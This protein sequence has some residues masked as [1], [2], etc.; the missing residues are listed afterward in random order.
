M[1]PLI[2]LPFP[3]HLHA[4]HSLLNLQLSLHF[5][6]FQVG[7][8][9]LRARLTLWGCEK[10]YGCVHLIAHCIAGITKCII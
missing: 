10:T 6:Q 9:K 1:P 8:R 3:A 5:I 7:Q 4:V 2:L